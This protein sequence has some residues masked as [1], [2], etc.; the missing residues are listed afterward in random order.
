[1]SNLS[2]AIDALAALSEA[3]LQT[4]K[5]FVDQK[6]AS[7]R[8]GGAR[9]PQGSRGKAP[10]SKKAPPPK[11]TDRPPEE[12]EFRR[13]QAEVSKARK[14]TEKGGVP[15]TVNP[16]LLEKFAAAKE[17]WFSFKAKAKNDCPVT[18]AEKAAAAAD[19][20]ES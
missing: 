1:M 2:K 4:C 11:K 9:L 8:K 3:E 16:Q 15:Q 7:G 12:V 18:E 13:L 14:P 5:T 19:S 20:S 6:L 17:T 10:S